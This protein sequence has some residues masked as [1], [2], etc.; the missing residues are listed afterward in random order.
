[1]A[2]SITLF[3]GDCEIGQLYEIF[4]I[5]GTPNQ[6]IWPDVVNLP[7]YKT[8]FPKWRGNNIK[9]KLGKYL[10]SEG[11]E[12]IRQMLIYD[13][14]RRINAKTILKHDYF[15]HLDKTKL[16]CGGYNGDILIEN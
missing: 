14:S 6:E 3:E 13:P 8:T 10:R 7:D 15:K 5:L 16:P 1:M 12:L 4:R 9:E 11:I 2:S